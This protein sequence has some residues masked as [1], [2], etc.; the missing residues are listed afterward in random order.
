[1][2]W[3]IEFAEGKEWDGGSDLDD[4]EDLSLYHDNAD[5]E[6]TDRDTGTHEQ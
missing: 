6:G 1:M 5:N 4:D 3:V 2:N